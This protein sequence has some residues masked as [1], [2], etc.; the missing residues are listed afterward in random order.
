MSSSHFDNFDFY[1]AQLATL[2][3]NQRQHSILSAD[4]SPVMSRRN[5]YSAASLEHLKSMNLNT[6]TLTL[7]CEKDYPNQK[8]YSTA[9]A[10]EFDG[11]SQFNSP[12]P[13]QPQY[14]ALEDPSAGF[15]SA[16][17]GNL[18]IGEQAQHE[19]ILNQ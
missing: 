10:N 7:H 3:L 19:H 6:D 12:L 17:I 18:E 1:F 16:F 14:A 9:P 2:P 11:S 4:N 8:E 15:N 5:S 13:S